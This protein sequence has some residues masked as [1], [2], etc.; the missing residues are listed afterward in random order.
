M[1]GFSKDG[2]KNAL[3]SAAS[4][5]VNAFMDAQSAENLATL[6]EKLAS[7]N[8]QPENGPEPSM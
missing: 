6:R 2:I 3:N 8:A 1:S 7:T 5:R 4:V